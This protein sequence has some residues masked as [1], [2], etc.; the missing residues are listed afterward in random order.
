MRRSLTVL[1]AVFGAL[2]G[3]TVLGSFGWGPVI[4]TREGEQKIVLMFGKALAVT[5]PGVFARVPLLMDAE[6][7]PSLKLYLNVDPES[8]QTKD[9]ERIVIDNYVVWRITDPVAFRGSFPEGMATAGQR[10]NRVVKAAVREIV[11]KHTLLD[12]LTNERENI[13]DAITEMAFVSFA[14]KGIDIEDVRIT[15]TEL[16]PA[17]EKNV[18]A[19]MKTDRERLARKYRAEGEEKARTI[20]ADAEREARVTVAHA[21]KQAEIAM[22]EGDAEAAR[23]YA[24]AYERDPEFYAFLRTMEAYRSTIGSDTTLVLSPDSEFFRYLA[25]GSVTPGVAAGR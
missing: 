23:I 13:R 10:I 6:T 9:Q 5:N 15:R 18:F 20:R 22:G 8:I 14:K 3:L 25:G 12:V 2:V 17:T 24:E 11:G 4:I 7:Y 1:L 19:R 16:P 21:R